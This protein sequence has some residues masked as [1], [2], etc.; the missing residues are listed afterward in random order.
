MGSRFSEGELGCTPKVA[1]SVA[2]VRVCGS[3]VLRTVLKRKTVFAAVGTRGAVFLRPLSVAE[4][5]EYVVNFFMHHY[6]EFSFLSPG[7]LPDCY[8]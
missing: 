6:V 3:F 7:L 8:L 1:L 4:W 2:A 5:L